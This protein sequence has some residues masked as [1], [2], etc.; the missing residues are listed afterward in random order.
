[1]LEFLKESLRRDRQTGE[2]KLEDVVHRIIYP[3]QAT[4]ADVPYE[5]QNLW[6]IDERLAFHWYLQSDKRLSSAPGLGSKSSDRPDLL[7]FESALSFA[8]DRDA[9]L[10][11]VVIVE[12]KKP[13][14]KEYRK[15]DPAD[16]AYR[17][18]SKIRSGKMKDEHG[19]PIKVRARDVP[20]YG[21]I[22]CDLP[23]SLDERLKTKNFRPTADGEGR[24]VFNEGLNVYLEVIPYDKLLREAEKR[25]RALF[26]SLNLPL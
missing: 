19:R 7:I 17:L 22:V 1:M 8:A 6:V 4:S 2:Y 26:E 11:S 18:I 25:N 20:A 21:Y 3:M 10:N 12:F 23:E 14:R 16:Q 15:E 9:P 5:Q 24:W 13:D